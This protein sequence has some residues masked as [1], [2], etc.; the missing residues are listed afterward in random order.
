MNMCEFYER[1]L[2]SLLIGFMLWMFWCFV[3]FFLKSREKTTINFFFFLQR[4]ML[5]FIFYGE[6]KRQNAQQK[7]SKVICKIEIF[8]N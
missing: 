7:S 4:E 6:G 8:I 2:D 5:A 3:L 1:I